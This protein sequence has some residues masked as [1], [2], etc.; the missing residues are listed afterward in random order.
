[1]AKKRMFSMDVVDTDKFLDMSA[2]SQCL[3]FHLGMRADDDG[4][5]SSPKKIATMAN[6]AVDD[7]K[8][9]IAK[10]YLI[11]ME[12]GVVVITEWLVNNKVQPSR[13]QPTRFENELSRL[14]I[15]NNIYFVQDGEKP[16]IYEMS[17]ICQQDVDKPLT[18][19]RLG[20]V[21]LDKVSKEKHLGAKKCDERKPKPFFDNEQL[22][23]AFLDYV[24]MRKK[25][26]KPLATDKAME[27]AVN[28][29][30]KLSS[31][32]G[33]MDVDMAIKILDQ[34]ILSSWQGL[35]P[36]KETKQTTHAVDWDNV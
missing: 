35:F 21:R 4:F 29:L 12:D 24:E 33:I 13:K 18:Q 36:L 11:P 6:C 9:L 27:L 1:M 34:S 30:S 22:N 15:N 19:V 14:G 3:Y 10:G 7:L 26:K 2:S 17:T 5:V 16:A 25:I 20:K 28:K 31:P 23:K 8:V 32:N